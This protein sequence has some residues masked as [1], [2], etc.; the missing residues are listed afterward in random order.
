M[1]RNDDYGLLTTLETSND[2]PFVTYMPTTV[3]VLYGNALPL[4]VGAGSRKLLVK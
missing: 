3:N 2:K 1:Q 4:Y